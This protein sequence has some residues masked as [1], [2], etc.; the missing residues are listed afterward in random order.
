[1]PRLAL[2]SSRLRIKVLLSLLSLRRSMLQKSKGHRSIITPS[3]YIDGI[4][5]RSRR[6]REETLFWILSPSTY[7]AVCVVLLLLISVSARIYLGS[8]SGYPPPGSGVSFLTVGFIRRGFQI[9]KGIYRQ[10]RRRLYD[11]KISVLIIEDPQGVCRL[12]TPIHV[13]ENPAPVRLSPLLT[14]RGVDGAESLSGL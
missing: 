1:M 14:W 5:K 10:R 8:S 13:K 3:A 2:L 4:Q 11:Q 12:G 6:D 9:I 7:S